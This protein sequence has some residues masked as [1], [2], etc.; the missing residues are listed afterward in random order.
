MYVIQHS[1]ICRPSDSTV[2]KDAG[3]KP[4]TV[5]TLALTDRRRSNQ[6]ARSHPHSTRSHPHS[7][8]SHPNSYISH[9]HSSN[10]ILTRIDLIHTRLDLAQTRLDPI[11]I[12]LE[13][14][15]FI[16]FEHKDLRCWSPRQCAVCT[17]LCSIQQV[18]NGRWL[19]SSGIVQFSREYTL[20]PSP[21]QHP[22]TLG[23][24][25]FNNLMGFTSK[26]MPNNIL[27]NVC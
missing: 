8:R 15:D 24:S 11:N 22:P 13:E 18:F 5:E 4:R 3:I 23:Y 20:P 19:S 17:M 1:F 27:S 16:L 25:D 9:P 21:P 12:A 26:K 7:A 2:S 10:L 14:L 6:S